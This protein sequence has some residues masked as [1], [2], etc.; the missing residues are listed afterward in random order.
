MNQRRRS[1][2]RTVTLKRIIDENERINLWPQLNM[3]CWYFFIR[4]NASVWDSSQ[5]QLYVQS[6]LMQRCNFHNI[7]FQTRIIL[8]YTQSVLQSRFPAITPG[9]HYRAHAIFANGHLVFFTPAAPTH[10]LSPI[11]P[12][13]NSFYLLDK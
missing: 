5:T 11:A 10:I 9:G 7:C 1:W 8:G 13:K 12:R 4:S 6:S 3:V 2:K